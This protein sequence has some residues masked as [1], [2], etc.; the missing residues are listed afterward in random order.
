MRLNKQIFEFTELVMQAMETKI[1][2]KQIGFA[3][4]Q[5]TKFSEERSELVHL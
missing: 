1:N 2:G 3:E 5:G 4:M